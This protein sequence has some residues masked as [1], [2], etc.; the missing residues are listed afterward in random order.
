MEKGLPMPRTRCYNLRGLCG[1][2]Q[3]GLWGWGRKGQR[4]QL[5]M[6][7]RGIYSKV[8]IRVT[9]KEELSNF[10]IHTKK[11]KL[12]A[13]SKSKFANTSSDQ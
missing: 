6:S 2:W 13:G 5:Y 1:P 3:S 8:L 4:S 9:G 11:N 12:L 7:T 10:L